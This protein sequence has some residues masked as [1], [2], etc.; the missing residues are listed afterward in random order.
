VTRA[1]LF[2]TVL[3][4]PFFLRAEA[5]V[6]PEGTVVSPAGAPI[7]GALVG[8]A[9]AEGEEILAATDE[10]GRFAFEVASATPITLWVRA[11]GFS[12]K[13]IV[14]EG[15]EP[16]RIVLSPLSFADDVTVTA[17]RGPTRIRDTAES[18]VFVSAQDIADA[19]PPALDAILRQVPGFSLFRRSDS[20]SANPTTQGA[21]LRGLGGSGTSRALVLDDGI[22]LNDPFGG[23]IAWGRV[24]DDALDRVEVVRGGSSDLY[25]APALS[26]VIQM[27]RRDPAESALSAEA[28]YGSQDTAD[29][30]AF[31]SGH[32]GAWTARVA[33]GAFRTSGYV[34]IPESLAGNVDAPVNSRHETAEATL[35]RADEKTRM[36]LRGAYYDEDR[37]NG[38]PLQTNDTRLWQ[39][40]AGADGNLGRG[41]YTLRVYGLDSIYHQTFTSVSPDRNSETLTRLQEVP[42]RAGG[43]TAQWDMTAGAHRLLAG[44]EGR[45]VSGSSNETV[46]AAGDLIAD[47]GGRQATAAAFVED[48]LAMGAR[49]TLSAALRFDA[50]R[51]DDAFQRNGE[52]DSNPPEIPLASRSATA[53]SPRLS[54][55]YQASSATSLTASAY[56]SFR[57]PTLNELYRAFRVGNVVTLANDDLGPERLTGGEVGTLISPPGTAFYTRVT[58]FWMEIDGTIVNRTLSVTPS[59]ITR[60][61]E[62]L[63]TTRSRGVEVDLEARLSPHV[64][65]SAGYLYVDAS[66]I[67][68]PDTSAV[69]RRIPQVPRNQATL[70]LRGEAGPAHLAVQGRYSA[71][72]FDDDVNAFRLPGFVQ[73]DA[74]G[75]YAVSHAV[76]VFL[77]G[78]NLTGKQAITGL[79]PL[80]TLGPPRQVRGG[81][82]V[83]L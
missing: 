57:A 69:G 2:I 76:E 35:E 73:V 32:F 20:R 65:A 4:A 80:P 79:T 1:A 24:V 50:W 70:Q 82:R 12:D 19:A 42:A 54:L 7:P 72:Q 52:A 44:L 81:V 71:A 18:V 26:G 14:W 10:T 49:L 59:L 77:A 13:L 28:S 83:G 25:G 62:N 43:G 21:S 15:S 9:E 34:V 48:R 58:A 31:V 68:S 51:N 63:G 36:F 33:A 29:A 41:S 6:R 37:D 45:V 27:I 3:A 74:R 78:E 61:R 16:L 75:G 55:I 46:G 64:Q 38:T 47:A 30:S 66:V 39:I 8:V 11:D 53:W 56:R 40:A 60:Q 5:P 22:P 67:R 17:S 23:W